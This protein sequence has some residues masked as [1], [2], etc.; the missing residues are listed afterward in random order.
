MIINGPRP[1]KSGRTDEEEHRA[2]TVSYDG[3][4]WHIDAIDDDFARLFRE[5][6]APQILPVGHLDTVNDD[7]GDEEMGGD[8][9]MRLDDFGTC[10]RLMTD[11]G[12]PVEGDADETTLDFTA[13]VQV[14]EEDAESGV[15]N[16]YD[17]DDGDGEDADLNVDYESLRYIQLRGD[18]SKLPANKWG[19]YSQEFGEAEHVHT[20]DEVVEHDAG[21]WGIVDYEDIEKGSLSLLIF[22]LDTHKAPDDWDP[23]RINLPED[24]LVTR[25]QN[26]GFHVYYRVHVPRGDL[27]ESDFTV[28]DDLPFDIDIRGSA[29]SHHVVAPNDI[30][31]VGGSYEIV[32]DAEIDTVFEPEAAAERI[33][34]DGESALRI[35]TTTRA[36][37]DWDRPDDAPEDMPTCYH[38]ALSLRR[39]AP[40]DRPNTH[41]VNVL[42]ALCGL[43]A[44][45]DADA[46]ARHMCGEYAPQD[47]GADLSDKEETEYQVRHIEEMLESGRYS[48]PALPSLRAHG[49]LGDGESCGDDCPI[50]LHSPWG[51][52]TSDDTHGTDWAAVQENRQSVE[53]GIGSNVV[54]EER[55]D[56]VG[57]Q[58]SKDDDGEKDEIIGLTVADPIDAVDDVYCTLDLQTARREHRV[59]A[60]MTTDLKMP[61]RVARRV[62]NHEPVHKLAHRLDA[63][64]EDCL[65][66]EARSA[67]VQRILQALEVVTVGGQDDKT[68]YV[69]D[70]G[71]GIYDDD[72][73]EV[74]RA[75]V[76]SVCPARASDHEKREIVSKIADRTREPSSEAFEPRGEFDTDW[77]DYRVVGNG[78]LRLPTEQSDGSVCDPELLEFDPDLRARKRIPIGYNTDAD[79]LEVAE[80]LDDIT[81]REEDRMAIEELVGNALLPDYRHPKITMLH[82]SGRNSKGVLLD[83]LAEMMG[84]VESP[85]VAGNSL[86]ELVDNDFRGLKMKHALVNVNGE[87][88]GRKLSER[89]ASKLKELTGGEPMEG[90]DKQVSAE[91]FRNTATV[92]FGAN[93]PILPPETQESWQERWV[94]I[95]LPYSYVPDPDP[96]DP[97]QK[98]DDK[99][100]KRKLTRE[101]NLEAMLLL[102]VEGLAR[103]EEQGDVSLPESPEERLEDYALDADPISRVEVELLEA[104]RNPSEK[105]EKYVPKAAVY[106]GYK[107]MARD[108]GV[109]PIPK[110]R[111]FSILEDRMEDLPYHESR[112]QAPDGVDN[113]REYSLRGVRFREDAAEHLSDYWL[114]HP[115]VEVTE[116]AGDRYCAGDGDREEIDIADVAGVPPSLLTLTGERVDVVN[117]GVAEWMP[118]D[119]D[120][121]AFGD[122]AD[123]YSPA[124]MDLVAFGEPANEDDIE[125]PCHVEIRGAVLGE[126]EGELQLQMDEDTV[127][128]VLEE[129]DDDQETVDG[130]TETVNDD[131]DAEGGHTTPSASDGGESAQRGVRA[132]G[133]GDGS[134]SEAIDTAVLQAAEGADTVAA[135]AGRVS[136]MVE[137][138][139]L[140]QIKH[141]IE[142]LAERGDIILDEL[143]IAEDD[144]GDGSE[145]TSNHIPVVEA[146]RRVGGRNGLS[147]DDAVA[148]LQHDTAVPP[149]KEREAL[150]VAEAVDVTGERVVVSA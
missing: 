90:E 107:S 39:E 34:L 115:W 72:G 128:H 104:A 100:I 88:N 142:K 64:Y 68:L 81:A 136:G 52:H 22:D 122:A 135:V 116:T 70:P 78:I 35:D 109:E 86:E 123:R 149:G 24:T 6:Q 30:P 79:T 129:T 96:N 137:T 57:W 11:G 28:S 113:N 14:P 99:K 36:D 12:K 43:A 29:V 92:F 97:F 21:A 139:D 56:V 48:P 25:S 108:D 112:P 5:G 8:G 144:G 94:P 87:L 110:N 101:E 80:W 32:N 82:G 20:H 13:D 141:R 106:E 75:V 10:R 83:V 117:A 140:D 73:R 91:T 27:D 118:S 4:Q 1:N 3:E 47:G 84:G 95:E 41:K 62:V 74:V 45:Y 85:N 54:I 147:I 150:E 69:Y 127:V 67:A 26:G 60:D 125:A 111:F 126:Y 16:D 38:A 102:A 17:P 89:E 119:T 37:I 19:G 44:G 49:I 114:S 51:Q 61:R 145:G 146:L 121:H 134:D 131:D 124:V 9:Q 59:D 132:D 133:S 148:V 7:S 143:T 76:E 65:N 130:A 63:L 42:A 66:A 2:E 55:D 77:D 58:W 98:Q 71:T 15:P 93:S 18:D 40:D 31:G 23:S 103:L 50:D 138:D 53:W 46:V 120:V 33:E 105:A